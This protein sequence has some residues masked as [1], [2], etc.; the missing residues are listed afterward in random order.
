MDNLAKRLFTNLKN[1]LKAIDM[2]YSLPRRRVR[3]SQGEGG[4]SGIK[5]CAKLSGFRDGQNVNL[6]ETERSQ[7]YKPMTS[8][9]NEKSIFSMFHSSSKQLVPGNGGIKNK[10]SLMQFVKDLGETTQK[11][12]NQNLKRLTWTPNH[13]FQG[14]SLQISLLVAQ[15]RPSCRERIINVV[16][17]YANNSL[18]IHDSSSREKNILSRENI[19]INSNACKGHM[20]VRGGRL[21]IQD[22][23]SKEKNVIKG[24]SID[25][26]GG[27]VAYKAKN[28]VKGDGTNLGSIL[29]SK[30]KDILARVLE[31]NSY[32]ESESTK[33]W[34]GFEFPTFQNEGLNSTF[35]NFKYIDLLQEAIREDFAHSSQNAPNNVFS[36]PPNC[37]TS[38][39]NAWSTEIVDSFRSQPRL[40][41]LHCG[42]NRY[43]KSSVYPSKVVNPS[44]DY[45]ASM[46]Q[47][48][49]PPLE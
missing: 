43:P 42:G 5:L 49:E 45:K 30:K 25:P 16:T 18:G 22:T 36:Y 4:C 7:T 44:S 11:M 31:E 32:R 46:A 29:S 13:H 28:V 34:L 40:V 37:I 10:E 27:V 9:I 39:K 12:A 33:S 1:D 6:C 15:Q 35:A 24:D 17:P 41:E 19:D 3:R 21:E 38:N 47:I 8:I 2:E 20:V 26:Y 23:I 14:S 48:T